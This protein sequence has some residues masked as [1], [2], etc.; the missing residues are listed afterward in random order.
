M[1]LTP[2]IAYKKSHINF[3]GVMSKYDVQK[4]TIQ[5][6]DFLSYAQVLDDVF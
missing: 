6:H 2:T 5:L 4:N 1:S 3:E